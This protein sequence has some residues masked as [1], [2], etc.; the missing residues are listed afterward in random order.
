MPSLVSSS[1]GTSTIIE[2]AIRFIS[3]PWQGAIVRAVGLKRNN[4]SDDLRTM[5]SPPAAAGE[6]L[7]QSPDRVQSCGELLLGY[8]H[9]GRNRARVALA[10]GD[11]VMSKA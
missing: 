1:C 11:R 3:A 7:P 9:R 6:I 10:V 4:A 2:I 8:Y 5:A